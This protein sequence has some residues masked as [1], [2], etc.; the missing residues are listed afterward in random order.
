MHNQKKQN[1]TNGMWAWHRRQDC[2]GDTGLDETGAS[3]IFDGHA[4]HRGVPAATQQNNL[5]SSM[6][7]SPKMTYRYNCDIYKQIFNITGFQ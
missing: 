7:I 1:Q 5:I 4:E 3:H 2:E 6:G